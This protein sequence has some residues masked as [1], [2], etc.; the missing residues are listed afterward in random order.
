MQHAPQPQQQPQAKQDFR[1][2]YS[3]LQTEM[4]VKK[5]QEGLASPQS[6][7]HSALPRESQATVDTDFYQAQT[8]MYSMTPL[9]Q[10]INP[11]EMDLKRDAFKYWLNKQPLIYTLLAVVSLILFF[12]M[13]V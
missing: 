12:L 1:A 6:Q 13:G 3:Q 4:A 9:K 5:K 7:N 10:P 8:K 11:E 2:V